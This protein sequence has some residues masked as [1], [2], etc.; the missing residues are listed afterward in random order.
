MYSS[1]DSEPREKRE[2]EEPNVG[3]CYSTSDN[4]SNFT[5]NQTIVVEVALNTNCVSQNHCKCNVVGSSDSLPCQS[6]LSNAVSPSST[7]TLAIPPSIIVTA[8]FLTVTCSS[9]L[10][11]SDLHFTVTVGMLMSVHYGPL[12]SLLTI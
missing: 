11:Q 8:S 6:N 7:L 12:E 2:G 1:N 10:N 4:G 3:D 5:G 9:V